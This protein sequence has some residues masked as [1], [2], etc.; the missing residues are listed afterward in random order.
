VLKGLRH[1]ALL[2]AT[3]LGVREALETATAAAVDVRAGG[4]NP[5][6]RGALEPLEPGLGEAPL[7]PRDLD[8][9][10]VSRDPLIDEHHPA[11][12]ASDGLPAQ[13]DIVYMNL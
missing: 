3:L 1:L 4:R 12:V 11:L 5:E 10:V 6:R 7:D 9:E 2:D 8:L 13:G